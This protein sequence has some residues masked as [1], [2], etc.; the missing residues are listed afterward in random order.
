MIK[1]EIPMV[2]ERVRQAV[3]TAGET[4]EVTHLDGKTEK[5]RV[6]LL[7]LRLLPDYQRHSGDEAAA[8]AL[9]CDKLVAWTDG[10][11]VESQ[12]KLLECGEA[13]NLDPLS[14]FVERQSARNERLLPGMTGQLMASFLGATANGNGKTAATS[15]AGSPGPSPQAE[16]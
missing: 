6:R 12:L 13:L 11:T 3:V 1:R 9:F 5:V 8:I 4:V 2:G 16:G 7:P 14:R 15:P 10:L